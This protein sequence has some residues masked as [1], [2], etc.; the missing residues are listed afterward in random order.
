MET[1]EIA[2]AD[3]F[4]HWKVSITGEKIGIGGARGWWYGGP[5]RTG[6]GGG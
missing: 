5:C 3:G 6:D 1:A 2:K 4:A